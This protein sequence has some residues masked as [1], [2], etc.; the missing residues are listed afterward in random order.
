MRVHKYG[1]E[2]AIMHEAEPSALCNQV[3]IR[4]HLRIKTR[5]SWLQCVLN[6]CVS[7]VSWMNG[8]LCWFA[9]PVTPMNWNCVPVF[10]RFFKGRLLSKTRFMPRHRP[11]GGSLLSCYG[12]SSTTTQFIVEHCLIKRSCAHFRIYLFTVKVNNVVP[13]PYELRYMSR[14]PPWKHLLWYHHNRIEGGFKV[15]LLYCLHFHYNYNY[16]HFITFCRCAMS[17]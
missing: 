4:M 12:D 8:L 7:A 17:T 2:V 3:P 9:A 11:T 1:H 6:W 13:M 15:Q 10:T 16:F 14:R 5:M